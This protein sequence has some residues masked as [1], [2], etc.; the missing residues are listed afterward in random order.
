MRDT[1]FL[2]VF[3]ALVTVFIFWEFAAYDYQIVEAEQ[4]CAAHRGMQKINYNL[5]GVRLRVNC[6]DGTV[7]LVGR[8][9]KEKDGGQ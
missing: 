4:T 3:G 7:V 2:G 8:D 6:R 5:L 9:Q 1:F